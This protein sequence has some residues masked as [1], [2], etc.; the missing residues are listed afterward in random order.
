MKKIM[1][2]LTIL[3]LAATLVCAAAAADEYPQPEGGKKFET[4]W[5]MRGGLVTID[6]EEEGYRVSVD[7][8]NQEEGKGVLW[9]YNCYYSEEKDALES[10]AASKSPYTLD[11][12][13]LD[14]TLEEPEYESLADGQIA[15]FTIDENGFLHWDDPFENSGANLQFQ[16]IGAFE[17]EWKNDAEDVFVQFTWQGMDQENF[18]YHVFIHRG[19]DA[20]YAEFSM[21]GLYNPE[22]GRLEASGTCTTMVRNAEGSYDMQED[23]KTYEAFFTRPENGKLVFETDNGIELEYDIL[24]SE[25]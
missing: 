7:L 5:A 10:I 20:Q 13:T 14:K 16:D 18:F 12:V 11:P 17:G 21:D 2:V 24:G 9:Q 4:F 15:V 25:S 3:A 1:S 22:T 23:G 6:Y 19:G 8:Q